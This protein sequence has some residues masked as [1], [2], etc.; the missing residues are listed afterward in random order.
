MKKQCLTKPLQKS[1]IGANP[2][3]KRL[4][5]QADNDGLFSSPVHFCEHGRYHSKRGCRKH[6]YTEHGQYYYF[7]EKPEMNKVFLSL[8]TRNS[9]YKLPQR[10]KT[11]NMPMFLK[12]CKVDVALNYGDKLLVEERKS[13]FRLTKHCV[14]F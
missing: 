9:T 3:A 7:E 11:S 10:S 8:N 4:K 14:K 1:A 6:V 2:K 5:L 12:T 13:L